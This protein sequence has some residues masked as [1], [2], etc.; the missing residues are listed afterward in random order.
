MV[1]VI[2]I[3]MNGLTPKDVIDM[4]SLKKHG[5]GNQKALK[6][7]CLMSLTSS[8]WSPGFKRPSLDTAPSGKIS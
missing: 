6:T 3:G 2:K 4:L 1:E 7:E 8:I 5:T